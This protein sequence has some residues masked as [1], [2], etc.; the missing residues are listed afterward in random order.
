MFGEFNPFA[1]KIFGDWMTF[2]MDYD[3]HLGDV[4]L[5]GV[6][7]Y[8]A[9]DMESL[10]VAEKRIRWMRFRADLM[11]LDETIGDPDSTVYQW[12]AQVED[13]YTELFCNFGE[14]DP[15]RETVE[16]SVR[17]SCFFP[18]KTGLNYIFRGYKNGKKSNW[19]Y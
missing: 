9:P 1:T 7:M 16:I 12:Y 8:E 18:K 4:Y 19:L 15:N 3:V 10:L 17:P 2:P 13:S 5:N 14:Y 11:E 6:S